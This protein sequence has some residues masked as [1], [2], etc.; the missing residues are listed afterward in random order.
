M[1]QQAER[2]ADSTPREIDARLTELL[3]TCVEGLRGPLTIRALTGGRSNPTFLLYAQGRCFVLR[4]RP[5]AA[6]SPS[7]HRIDREVRV[8][9]AL[10][11]SGVPVPRVLLHVADTS[12]FGA[13]FYLMTL[14]DGEAIEDPAL[15]D[16]AASLRTRAYHRAIDILASLHK[17]PPDAIGLAGFGGQG[18]YNARQF[19]R[20]SGQMASDGCVP[21]ALLELGSVLSRTL[22][23]QT[24]T[25]VVHGDY[26]F[27]NL[28]QSDGKISAVLDWELSTLGDPFADLAYFLLPFDL[29]RG[30]QILPGLADTS[31]ARGGIP[32]PATLAARYCKAIG[33]PLPPGWAAYCAF[34]LYRTAAIA[35]GVFH[36]QTAGSLTADQVR[37]LDE[38]AETGL[39]RLGRTPPT[40]KDDIA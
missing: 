18:D 23:R 21:P 9:Q 16:L 20:W 35:H 11:G 17:L 6:S 29:P 19:T 15:P 22:P 14:V 1:V 7:A 3:E 24:R 38:L 27:G 5:T 32:E 25:S 34:A 36:R 33:L 13:P 40:G 28:L 8:L 39:A 12:Y 30:G 26:R 37:Q 4:S 10:E 2:A 31:F